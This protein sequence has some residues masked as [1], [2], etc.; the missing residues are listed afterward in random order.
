MSRLDTGPVPRPGARPLTRARALRA[1]RK[2]AQSN[3]A[4]FIAATVMLVLIVVFGVFAATPIYET[5]LLWVVAAAGALIP[6]LVVWLGRKFRWGALTLAALALVFTVIVVPL[7]VP[8]AIGGGPIGILR[9][10]GDGLAA[11]ALGWKQLLTLT[12]P[13]GSYQ[14]VLVPFLVVIFGSA[15]ASTALTLRGGKWTPFAALTI[16]APVLFGTVFGSSAVSAP[17]T[18][19][20]LDIAAP[21]ELALWL[22]AFG[23][24]VSWVAWSSGRARRAAL[25][26]GR[27]ADSGLSDA[28][29]AEQPGESNAAYRGRGAVR[30]NT[31][32]RGF[33]AGATVL[34]A[35]AGAFFLA[36]IVTQETRTVPRDRVDPE[37]VVRSNVSP[38]AA[39]RASKRDATLDEIMFTVTSE[40]EDGALPSRLRLAVLSQYDGVDFTV[41]DPEDVG[42]FTRF[43]SGGNVADPRSVLVEIEAGYSGVWVPI[44]PPLASP[45]VFKGPRASALSESFYLNRGTGSAVAVPRSSDNVDT[46]DEARSVSDGLQDGDMFTATMSAVEDAIPGSR[47]VSEQP[48]IDLDATPELARWIELQELPATGAGVT[49]AVERLRARGYLSHSLTDGPGESAWLDGLGTTSPIRFVSSTGGHSEARIEQLFEQLNEQQLAAGEDPMP[50]M[51]VAGI[52]DDE[53]FAAAAALIA[54]A[55]GF[56]SRVVVGVRLGEEIGDASSET[57][58]GEGTVGVP[59]VPGVPA[60]ASACTGEHLAAW[61]EVRGADRVWAPLDASPQVEIP[62]T[63]LQKGEQLPEFPTLPEE[64]NTHEAD[65]PVGMSSQEGGENNDSEANRLSALWPVLRT[66]GLSIFGLVLLGLVALFIP[67]LKRVR[68]GRRREAHAPE[69]RVLGAW[70]ELLDAYRDSGFELPS[71]GGRDAMQAAIGVPGGDWIAWTVDQAVYSREG[72]TAETADTLWSVVDARVAERRAE[73]STWQRIRARFSFASFGGLAVKRARISRRKRANE[74]A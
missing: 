7:A 47:P 6:A 53:Q 55:M 37:L 32:I 36:P 29:I 14:T 27:I 48:L 4:L 65:P 31:A 63:M 49:E 35:L 52:G 60:C 30:R 16:V 13:L 62:P 64:K 51:L 26:R 20:P 28:D 38:L 71:G 50:A 17:I 74:G 54:R 61:I 67:T 9:A 25:K 5:G 12:L 56:D 1:E 43:P 33:I 15:A 23:I 34:A 21:R 72:I 58:G 59:G 18:L 3:R 45:P 10:V 44:A 19:G 70:D 22:G 42:R 66:V 46:S 8:G 39:Y 69:A 73:L 11:V 24:A 2:R 57:G 40:E 68:T 41:G